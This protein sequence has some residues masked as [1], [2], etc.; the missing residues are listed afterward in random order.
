M[1]SATSYSRSVRHAKAAGREGRAAT[2]SPP[3]KFTSSMARPSSTRLPAMTSRSAGAMAAT[4]CL[5]R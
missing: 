4:S 5:M 3:E 2:S 1:S